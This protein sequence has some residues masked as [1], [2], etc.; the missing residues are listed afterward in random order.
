[1]KAIKVYTALLDWSKVGAL[2]DRFRGDED[3][4]A[5]RIDNNTFIAV[6][7]DKDLRAY[8]EKALHKELDEPEVIELK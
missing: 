8:F 7:G 3:F 2:L 5:T 1:M 6:F 4:F